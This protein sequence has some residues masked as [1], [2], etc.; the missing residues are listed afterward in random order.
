MRANVKFENI[1]ALMLHKRSLQENV[2]KVCR[3]ESDSWA[4]VAL[5]CFVFL[6]GACMGLWLCQNWR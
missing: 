2:K 3:C 5:G 1:A 6:L 4:L